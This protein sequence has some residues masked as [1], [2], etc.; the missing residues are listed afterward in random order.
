MKSLT[1]NA[2]LIAFFALL[3]TYPI[4]EIR[5]DFNS[6]QLPFVL[7]PYLAIATYTSLIGGLNFEFER[8]EKYLAYLFLTLFFSTLVKFLFDQSAFSLE[9]SKGIIYFLAP[10]FLIPLLKSLPRVKLL[11]ITLLAIVIPVLIGWYRFKTGEGGIE[12]EHNLN[13]WGI[14]YA[15]ASRNSDVLYPISLVL[16]S[17]ELSVLTRSIFKTGLCWLA[18][19]LGVTATALSL[20]RGG[21]IALAIG[22]FHF[23]RLQKRQ[24]RNIATLIVIFI[25]L[26][27]LYVIFAE[28]FSD[29]IINRFI[30]IGEFS[31]REVSNFDR[32]LIIMKSLEAMISL[33]FGTGF[34]YSDTV[35]RVDGN[36]LGNSE[37]GWLT[38]AVEGGFLAFI[39]SILLT[40]ALIVRCRRSSS[41][42]GLPLFSLL[43]TYLI[44]NYELNSIFFWTM[45]SIAWAMLSEEGINRGTR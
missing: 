45:V 43:F 44:F 29:E 2:L 38:I 10:F 22:M 1:V 41:P 25:I 16:I 21:W 30:S 15:E 39:F 13:Y 5:V 35:M 7:F 8:S 20:S 17:L 40:K 18:I 32:I 37:N 11:T 36:T 34:G 19:F 3:S 27:A 33:P 6:F 42:V 26:I 23:L 28:N 4:A 24:K 14:R 12:S 31:D 9:R